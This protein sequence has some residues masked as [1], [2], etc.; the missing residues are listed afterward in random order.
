MK[1]KDDVENFDNLE[2]EE[3]HPPPEPSSPNF[4]STRQIIM[5]KYIVKYHY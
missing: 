5:G 4:K 2:S 3:N 1:S